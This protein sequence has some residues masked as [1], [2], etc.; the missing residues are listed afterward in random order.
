MTRLEP[1]CACLKDDQIR[2]FVR[3]FQF[4]DKDRD[5]FLTRD[6]FLEA[7]QAVGIVPTQIERESVFEDALANRLTVEDF[8]AVL[9]YFLRAGETPEELIRAFA[10]FDDDHT[11]MIPVEKA[12]QILRHLKHPVSDVRIQEL[13]AKLDPRKEGSIDYREMIKLLLP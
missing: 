11:G 2:S 7:L 13:M 9:Y 6:E 5:G 4:S 12:T 1:V 8:V 10:V 3:A